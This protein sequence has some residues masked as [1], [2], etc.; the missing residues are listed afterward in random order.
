ML[1]IKIIY[2]HL[3][4]RFA[5]FALSGWAELMT[6]IHSF[7][8]GTTDLVGPWPLL[9]FYNLC[10]TDGKTPWTGD[11]LVARP[12]PTHRT[13]QTQ[14]KRTNRHPFLNSNSRSQHSNE[15]RQLCLRPRGHC[16]RHE[17]YYVAS[18]LARSNVI[19]WTSWEFSES[20][21]V[22]KILDVNA[23]FI[24]CWGASLR[25]S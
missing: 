13:T 11:Q 12:L 25:Q 17:E 10:Y 24:T 6:N 16:N 8:N 9:Q 3:L 19:L 15:R 18:S 5:C 2:F 1:L 23:P 14:N 7:I 20:A 4:L 22:P 21:L